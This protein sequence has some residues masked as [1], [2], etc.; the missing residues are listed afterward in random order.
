MGQ[1]VRPYGDDEYKRDGM[2]KILGIC[3][4]WYE[5]KGAEKDELKVEWKEFP[6]IVHAIRLKDNKVYNTTIN[7]FSPMTEKEKTDAK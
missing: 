4:D 3:R 1:L 5:Y 7:F 2:Y 6:F